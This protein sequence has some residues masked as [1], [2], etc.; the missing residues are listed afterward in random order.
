MK[1]C[2]ERSAL[3]AD[4]DSMSDTSG[5][6]LAGRLLVAMPGIGDPRFER[7]LVF[8]CLHDSEHALG[9]TVNRP[10]EGLTF[11]NLLERLDLKSS[12][13]PRD[14]LVLM[15]G[16]VE[17]E[18]GFVLHTDDYLHDP[19]SVPVVGGL[20]LTATR[21]VLEAMANESPHPRRAILA[22]GYAG[23]APGQLENEIRQNVWLTCDA[24]EDLLFDDDHAHKWSRSLAKLGISVE[25]LSGQAGRA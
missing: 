13:R 12:T 10:I 25:H 1:V 23:W 15:G 2:L 22:L 19:A 5:H 9:L 18:R 14:D 20:A 17:P 7:A 3:T 24:D 21:E 8:L 4:H 16:P 6:S 11:A